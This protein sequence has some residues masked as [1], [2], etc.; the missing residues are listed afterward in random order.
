[1]NSNLLRVPRHHRRNDDVEMSSDNSRRSHSIPSSNNSS[2]SSSNSNRS[3]S[4]RPNRNTRRRQLAYENLLNQHC[5]QDHDSGSV[6][7]LSH[8]DANTYPELTVAPQTRDQAKPQGKLPSQRQSRILK[9]KR[10]KTCMGPMAD[11]ENKGLKQII[12]SDLDMPQGPMNAKPPRKIAK[13]P[14]KVLDAP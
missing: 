6:H 7:N 14:F 11:Q 3:A 1:M 10:N 8:I 4:E 13:V 2:N 12:R 9:F 5:F